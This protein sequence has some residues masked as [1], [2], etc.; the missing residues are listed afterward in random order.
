MYTQTNIEPKTNHMFVPQAY[1]WR[2][3]LADKAKFG[4]HGGG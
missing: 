4:A 2:K 3:A 1:I